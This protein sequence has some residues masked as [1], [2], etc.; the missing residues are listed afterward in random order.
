MDRGAVGHPDADAS[1]RRP[2]SQR[3]RRR[4]FLERRRS[5]SSEFSSPACTKR[6]ARWSRR[7]RAETAAARERGREY[8]RN[9]VRQHPHAPARQRPRLSRRDAVRDTLGRQWPLPD[10]RGAARHLRM[11]VAH[12]R[13]DSLSS[14]RP[15]RASRSALTR[16]LWQRLPDRQRRRSSRVTARRR[17]GGRGGDAPRSRSSTGRA[18][19]RDRSAGYSSRGITWKRVEAG[20]L[21]SPN[22]GRSH[23]PIRP[24][25]TTSAGFR[26]ALGSPR[27]S[28]R[29]TAAR[30]RL[31]VVLP[32]DQINVLDIV[33]GKPT[34]VAAA[35]AAKPSGGAVRVTAPQNRAM[36]EFERRRRRGEWRLHDPRADRSPDT[37]RD[38]LT[39]CAQC[40]ECR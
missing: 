40:P 3:G 39:C 1:W 30:R 25:G 10:R 13:F 15:R 36:R 28:R 21:A 18:A 19:T 31:Q 9:G 20:R 11:S 37:R 5:P 16:R 29:T 32:D 8:P 26:T 22:A 24:D 14:G 12:A 4:S 7:C 2:V 38:S 17:S 6:V 35:S 27:G 34:V 23:A 33:I